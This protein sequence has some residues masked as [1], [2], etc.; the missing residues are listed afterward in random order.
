MEGCNIPSIS[1]FLTK[2]GNLLS[3]SDN[4]IKS[5][6]LNKEE[7]K[8]VKKTPAKKAAAPKKPKEK[9]ANVSLPDSSGVRE[10]Y[11]I[12]V[13]ESGSSYVSNEI[14]FTK[15]NRI[16]EVPHADAEALL[17]LENFRLPDQF[18]VEAYLNSKED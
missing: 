6:D 11:Q 14:R 10:G 5:T 1:H 2:Y 17:V 8:P 12:I 13:F 16:Q 4:I 15:D 3:M 9:T 7:S 18:E